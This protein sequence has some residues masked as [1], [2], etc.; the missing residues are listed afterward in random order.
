MS[1]PHESQADKLWLTLATLRGPVLKNLEPCAAS[2]FHTPSCMRSKSAAL[3]RR[4]STLAG[5]KQAEQG[6]ARPGS[7][8]SQSFLVSFY[9]LLPSSSH[10]AV[11]REAA[12]GALGSEE[13]GMLH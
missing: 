4:G 7:P 8:V 12:A 6:T 1:Q 2:G 10:S 9:S 11:F 5:G 13:V 3:E